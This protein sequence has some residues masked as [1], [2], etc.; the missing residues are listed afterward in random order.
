MNVLEPFHWYAHRQTKEGGCVSGSV[1]VPEDSG[2]PSEYKFLF[3]DFIFFEI[4][5]LIENPDAYCRDCLPPLPG[6]S[7]ET[8]YEV[9]PAEKER[10]SITDIFFGP[11]KDTQALYVVLRGGEESVIRIRYTGNVDNSPPVP[12]LQLKGRDS[13]YQ[14][15]EEIAFDGSK[16]SDPDGDELEFVWDFGDGM[17]STSVEPTH[18]FE[19]PGKYQVK[20]IVTDV[21]GIS[22]QMTTTIFIG[23][24]PTVSILSPMEGDEFYVGQI[25]QLLGEAFNYEGD[26]LDDSSLSWEVRK[27][28][29]DHFHPFLDPTQGNDFE[30]FPAP[31]PEDFFASTNSYLQ[32]ILKA[33]DENGLTTEVDRLVQ[34]LK[35][36]VD[37]ESHPSGVE[38]SVEAFP[39]TT[40]EQIVSWKSHKL[41]LFAKDQPPLLF[42]SWSDGNTEQERK[43]TIQEDGQLIL[44]IY[45]FQDLSSC[46]S[47][48]ECCSGVC[49]NMFCTGT[50]TSAPGVNETGI[51]S[52][53]EEN[54]EESELVSIFDEGGLSPGHTDQSLD[55]NTDS[56][57]LDQDVIEDKLH[58]DIESKDEENKEDSEFVSSFD[59]KDLFPGLLDQSLDEDRVSDS[60]FLDEDVVEDDGFGLHRPTILIPAAVL[61][62]LIIATLVVYMVRKNASNDNKNCKIEDEEIG[63]SDT[64]NA[65][66]DT[67]ETTSSVLSTAE[68]D[69]NKHF[70]DEET[71]RSNPYKHIKLKS[72]S[73]NDKPQN[74]KVDVP[75]SWTKVQ[76]KPVGIPKTTGPPN[77]AE[78]P[79]DT[80][81]FNRIVL[82]KTPT[83]GASVNVVTGTEGTK[84]T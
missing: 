19:N 57:F 56:E 27:H 8:F 53:N 65:L 22:Q 40:P 55:E 80:P 62:S 50:N 61:I 68:D 13:G 82:R 83:N 81:E 74:E 31:E 1:F 33:T 51:E 28:H 32:I 34:P 84:P 30:L 24:P 63:A 75:S 26:R 10:G 48:E 12:I 15:G 60:E 49:K 18:S 70:D 54:K 59:E 45:C 72:R 73:V 7:N 29:A 37:I 78:Q 16:S 38:M 77:F 14:V 3:A 47:N 9:P 69:S 4:Y 35:M 11:Y 2:W 67:F 21:A 41:N 39:L 23:K 76:L 64:P 71:A 52:K 36:N 79:S 25:F 46:S 43:I 58:D 20:L 44:A 6:Y 66:N 42:Q 5:N 17:S